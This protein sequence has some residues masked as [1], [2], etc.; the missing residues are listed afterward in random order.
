MIAFALKGAR[1][2]CDPAYIQTGLYPKIDPYEPEQ[3]GW[4]VM[5]NDGEY[6]G[7]ATVNLADYG[8]FPEPGCVFVKITPEL[9]GWLDSLIA[10]GFVEATGRILSA[11]YVKNYAVEC[12]VLKP[13]LLK[14]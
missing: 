4:R 2:F 12:R 7:M 5:S 13:E 8:D 14:L 3:F 9:G 11:G 1:I 6:L 10:A